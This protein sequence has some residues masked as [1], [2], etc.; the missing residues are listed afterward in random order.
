L[1][2]QAECKN[3]AKLKTNSQPSD[4]EDFGIFKDDFGTLAY[5]LA[6]SEDFYFALLPFSLGEVGT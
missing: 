6:S 5:S 4:F 1:H 2:S 3:H